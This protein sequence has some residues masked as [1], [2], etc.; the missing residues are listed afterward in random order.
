MR[1]L[2]RKQ[3]L[4]LLLALLLC[5]SL[6]A[7]CAKTETVEGA[8]EEAEVSEG[9]GSGGRPELKADATAAEKFA[10]GFKSLPHQLGD[11]IS[12]LL[13]TAAGE[14]SEGFGG[15]WEIECSL[16]ERG[17][18]Y[19][20][21][22]DFR[23]VL[24]RDPDSGDLSLEI[25]AP[26]PAGDESELIGIYFED[27]DLYLDSR[28]SNWEET[29]RLRLSEL[30]TEA[31]D[32]REALEELASSEDARE[33]VADLFGIDEEAAQRVLDELDLDR[34]GLELQEILQ[35]VLEDYAEEDT[36]SFELGDISVDTDLVS[37]TLEDDD[38]ADVIR[39]FRNLAC[40]VYE[41][42]Y[43]AVEGLDMVPPSEP[44]PNLPALEPG[45]YTDGYEGFYSD[46]QYIY[47]FCLASFLDVDAECGW[48]YLPW[49]F[50][51]GDMD[52]LG[53]DPGEFPDFKGLGSGVD[54]YVRHELED[55]TD[56]V[57]LRVSVE[58][59]G[60][61]PVSFG[62]ELEAD[63]LWA[64][65]EL[66]IWSGEEGEFLAIMAEGG[67]DGDD[68]ALE[69]LSQLTE[70]EDYDHEYRLEAVGEF[71]GEELEL[72]AFAGMNT[73]EEERE[74]DFELDLRTDWE[75]DI[76]AAGWMSWLGNDDGTEESAFEFALEYDDGWVD[77]EYE[78]KVDCVYAPDETDVGHSVWTSGD[79]SYSGMESLQGLLGGFGQEATEAPATSEGSR[80]EAV[81][82]AGGGGGAEDYPA[83][84]A[85]SLN[86]YMLDL[87]GISYDEACALFGSN[88]YDEAWMLYVFDE[89]D[90]GLAFAYGGEAGCTYV[91][92]QVEELIW[93]CPDVVD[94]STLESLMPGGYEAY[95]EME[96]RWCFYWWY[97]GC[98]VFIYTN[99]NGN[100][101]A[102]SPVVYNCAE[103][104]SG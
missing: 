81:P 87:A 10:H 93:G 9:E 79:P 86:T 85:V 74:L 91:Y 43:L 42:L 15:T 77:T 31:A 30:Q 58:L 41:T 101:T 23:L 76:H 12:D 6:F 45:Y 17:D 62:V 67:V 98:P 84:M 52:Y 28:G 22:N 27:G 1:E 44:N 94:V 83:A 51:P 65:L 56:G 57:S 90:L 92:T 95:D 60:D 50:L 75:L 55:L 18:S 33:L 78:A 63:D 39:Q 103:L 89:Y 11:G 14:R 46:G 26:A 20:W 100:Y 3:L 80:A 7:G 69:L 35:E 64:E 53:A 54:E 29:I 66:G 59:Y 4:A 99:S 96:G 36:D 104:V 72:I 34:I 82:A 24:V 40:E 5:L 16:E 102:D 2:R 37:V 49:D 38:L 70:G 21:E 19:R 88:F 32:G 47:R 97:Q 73:G 61:V 13:S 25:E 68:F 48:Q 8:G 71:D